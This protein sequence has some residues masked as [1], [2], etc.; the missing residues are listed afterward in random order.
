M[1][2]TKRNESNNNWITTNRKAI[3]IN[4]NSWSLL[5]YSKCERANCYSVCENLKLKNLP[6]S[7]CT[8][9][10]RKGAA[11]VQENL[12]N[13]KLRRRA[14]E[15]IEWAKGKGIVPASLLSEYREKIH[16]EQQHLFVDLLTLNSPG[17]YQFP[18]KKLWKNRNKQYQL[19]GL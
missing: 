13:T 2:Y 19:W 3:A 18:R 9:K 11:S 10:T 16:V 5:F 4:L 15:F 12:E 7:F 8:W 14:E 6:Y 1:F 17:W